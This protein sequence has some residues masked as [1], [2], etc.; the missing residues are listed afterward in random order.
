MTRENTETGE[1]WEA[2]KEIQ[3]HGSEETLRATTAP[4]DEHQAACSP[5]NILP[6]AGSF[7]EV[8]DDIML[9]TC[10]ALET[11]DG[12]ITLLHDMTSDQCG[13]RKKR[14]DKKRHGRLKVG[15]EEA[16]AIREAEKKKSKRKEKQ[17]MVARK[18]AVASGQDPPTGYGN[19]FLFG[20][21]KEDEGDGL[22]ALEAEIGHYIDMLNKEKKE[23]K[24][25]GE[26][27]G[28]FG[29]MTGFG[30]KQQ[31]KESIESE[32]QLIWR[33]LEE[34]KIRRRRFTNKKAPSPESMIGRVQNFEVETEEEREARITRMMDALDRRMAAQAQARQKGPTCK[35]IENDGDDQDDGLFFGLL[36]DFKVLGDL[37]GDVLQN[38]CGVNLSLLMGDPNRAVEAAQDDFYREVEN[39]KDPFASKKKHWGSKTATAMTALVNEQLPQDILEDTRDALM[40][41][42]NVCVGASAFQDGVSVATRGA[43]TQAGTNAIEST[44]VA[45]TTAGDALEDGSVDNFDVDYGG[46]RDPPAL[47]WFSFLSP[48]AESAPAEPEPMVVPNHMGIGEEAREDDE[49]EQ[50]EQKMAEQIKLVSFGNANTN[51]KTQKKGLKINAFLEDDSEEYGPSNKQVENADTFDDFMGGTIPSC[52][53]LD[54]R[55]RQ[56][57]FTAE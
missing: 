5:A 57:L 27:E 9:K 53:R 12:G 17:K 21:Q 56:N 11:L 31:N 35:A 30:E 20:E 2:E 43:T 36:D 10:E 6:T 38:D 33:A 42:P 46:S 15:V 50:Q 47:S 44:D 16:V 37:G 8:L 18:K 14:R 23:A 3:Q 55:Q 4:I 48:V 40:D 49:L 51:T 45:F 25:Q 54:Q 24:D 28:L 34:S 19:D 41:I 1:F 13:G 32:E 29:F 7:D 52:W 22:D 39:S 26:N